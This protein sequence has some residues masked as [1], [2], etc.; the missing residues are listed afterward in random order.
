MGWA[1]RYALAWR[2]SN[3][4]EAAR[5]R[6]S[7]ANTQSLIENVSKSDGIHLKKPV[8]LSRR[9]ERPQPD[10]PCTVGDRPLK[11]VQSMHS[12]AFVSVIVIIDL[13]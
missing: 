4:L 10:T 8:R 11:R 12:G 2:L 9:T 7:H 5:A 1:S 3:T 13:N 6:C